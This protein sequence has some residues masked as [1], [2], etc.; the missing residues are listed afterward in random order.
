MNV[1]TAKGDV[2]V[3]PATGKIAVPVTITTAATTET[4]NRFGG[5]TITI[6]GTGFGYVAANVAVTLTDDGTECRV[7]WVKDSTEITC[8]TRKVKQ[9]DNCIANSPTVTVVVNGKSA[10]SS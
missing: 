5:S 2:Y 10:V 4:V 8:V 1:K 7:M 3:A 9:I 6:A